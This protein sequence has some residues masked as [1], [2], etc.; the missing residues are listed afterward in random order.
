MRRFLKIVLP[1][2]C[3][4]FNLGKAQDFHLSM[5]DAGPLFLNPAMT[6]MVDAPWRV[7]AQYRNQWK[8]V[9]FKPYNTALISFDAPVGKWGFGGQ[10]TEMRAGIGGYNVFEA[11]GSAAYSVSI[12]RKRFHQLAMGLQAGVT[13]KSVEYNIYTFDSQYTPTNGGYFDKSLSNGENLA[14]RNIY[15]PQVNAGLLYFFSKQQS[16]INP[17]LGYSAFN[18]LQPKETFF[19]FNNKL[20]VRHYMH[21]G[22]RINITELFYIVPKVLVMVQKNAYEQ[23][24]ALDL[25]YYMKHDDIY[26][27]AGATYRSADA[28]IIY[29][30]A[31]KNNYI[32][33]IGYDINTS[34]LKDA[35]HERGAFE[36]S[37]T[38]MPRK[39]KADVIRNCPR[40]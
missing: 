36:I 14:N 7:H 34:S 18:L 2:F 35:S 19:G 29:I 24:Y 4:L 27:L 20:P 23:T 10:I 22:V 31:R 25:G 21:T 1:A 9:A 17:F 28:G 6:G 5:Y 40:L 16:R 8:A 15:L 13:Q 30:G 38:Y 37:F 32:A 39:K 33:K 26:L 3:L 12:D 11:I